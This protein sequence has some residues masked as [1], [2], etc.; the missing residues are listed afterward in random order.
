MAHLK[1][2]FRRN[3]SSKQHQINR[4]PRHWRS[5]DD[6]TVVSTTLDWATHPR[7]HEAFVEHTVGNTTRYQP[8]TPSNWDIFTT[9]ETRSKTI[10][11]AKAYNAFQRTLATEVNLADADA[12]ATFLMEPFVAQ[13][14]YKVSDSTCSTCKGSGQVCTA[15]TCFTYCPNNC[16]PDDKSL[17]VTDDGCSCTG[18]NYLAEHGEPCSA[19]DGTGTVEPVYGTRKFPR[20]NHDED[21]QG[22]IAD[23]PDRQALSIIQFTLNRLADAHES[24]SNTPDDET[25]SISPR[26]VL[27][28]FHLADKGDHD[29]LINQAL[30]Y[31]KP[32]LPTVSESD[33]PTD[34]PEPT[35][36]AMT[37]QAT[38]PDPAQL[39][40]VKDR[41]QLAAAQS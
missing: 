5:H 20:T 39:S 25:V 30:A 17:Y 12:I 35:P 6:N 40:R 32:T 8:Q 13:Y 26:K 41:L 31:I 22:I 1:H 24:R 2:A 19:C 3:T 10:I 28:L 34:T 18:C 23:K 38:K 4:Y 29:A 11:D 33:T 14:D 7:D 37:E 15:D 36:D 16:G 21:Q 27:Q 9:E